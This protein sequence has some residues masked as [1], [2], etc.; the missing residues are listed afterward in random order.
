[1]ITELK[2]LPAELAKYIQILSECYCNGKVHYGA[3]TIEDSN[4]FQELTT[5]WHLR[6]SG[7]KKHIAHQRFFKNRIVNNALCLGE[8][9]AGCS[10]AECQT[11]S[12]TLGGEPAQVLSEGG[13]Y[14]KPQLTRAAIIQLGNEAEMSMTG[15]N[16]DKVKVFKNH[17]HWSAFFLGVAWDYTFVVSDESDNSI[18]VLIATDT[19]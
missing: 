15:G 9:G 19:D 14:F 8:I 1:M 11:S 3:F 2:H 13:A 17:R 6:K 4:L 12:F 10:F 7:T 16:Y 18:K 5:P